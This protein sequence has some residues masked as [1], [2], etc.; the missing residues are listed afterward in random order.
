MCIYIYIMLYIYIYIHMYIYIYIPLDN[1]GPPVD[2]P[3]WSD[4]VGPWP[5]DPAV[6]QRPGSSSA[7]FWEKKRGLEMGLSENRVYSQ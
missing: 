1:N 3:I 6:H 4:P 7:P 5:T 2:L